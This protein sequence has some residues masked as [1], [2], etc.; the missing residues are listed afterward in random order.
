MCKLSPKEVVVELPP[1]LVKL[2]LIF[3]HLLEAIISLVIN[4]K[5]FPPVVVVV[6]FRINTIELKLVTPR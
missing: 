6:I 4:V 2:T 5:S 1:V 3:L